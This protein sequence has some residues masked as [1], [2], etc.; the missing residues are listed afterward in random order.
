MV[1]VIGVVAGLLL[2]G[3]A[4]GVEDGYSVGVIV[5]LCVRED[6]GCVNFVTP[7]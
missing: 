3:A 5:D 6:F 4:L 7:E 1:R 2:A